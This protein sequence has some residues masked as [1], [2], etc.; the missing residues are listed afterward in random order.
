MRASLDSSLTISASGPVDAATAWRRYEVFDLWPT[1]SPQLRRVEC[2]PD[3]LAAGTSGRAV[4][5]LGLW[6]DFTVLDVD[7]PARQWSWRVH[8]GPVTLTLEHGVQDRPGGSHTWLRLH[9][10]LPVITAY[11]PPA[12]HALHRLVTLP[13]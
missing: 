9:G 2:V 12:W 4:G 5:P 6:V 11:A 8:R 13:G 10:P 7:A 1:W 3:R